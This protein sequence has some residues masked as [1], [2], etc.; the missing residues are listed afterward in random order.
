MQMFAAQI[1]DGA[2]RVHR[3]A[4][5]PHAM[6]WSPVRHSPEASQHPAHVDA[7]HAGATD[8]QADINDTTTITNRAR[9]SRKYPGA[10][11]R[12]QRRNEN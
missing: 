4:P 6:F 10:F 11:G 8:A 2:Q 1:S 12:A 7:S 9:M 3:S 5:E